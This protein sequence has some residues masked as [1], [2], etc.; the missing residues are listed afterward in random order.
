[1]DELDGASI[2]GDAGTVGLVL[3]PSLG[4]SMGEGRRGEVTAATG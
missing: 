2:L 1:M 3:K 4:R